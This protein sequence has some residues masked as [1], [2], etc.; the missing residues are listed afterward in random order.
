MCD[1]S[2]V[3]VR[4]LLDLKSFYDG[5]GLWI[6]FSGLSVPERYPIMRTESMVV[7][8]CVL[9]ENKETLKVS[10]KSNGLYGS[11]WG[12]RSLQNLCK[13]LCKN[14]KLTVSSCGLFLIEFGLL[15]EVFVI[16]ELSSFDEK[17]EFV[18]SFIATLWK[19]WT[20]SLTLTLVK[21]FQR[22]YVFLVCFTNFFFFFVPLLFEERRLSLT[23]NNYFPPS[24]YKIYKNLFPDRLQGIR[25]VGRVERHVRR[26]RHLVGR[27]SLPVS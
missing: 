18:L 19:I 10:S 4:S 7:W 16:Q 2:S 23:R 5:I 17:R 15:I 14:E 13:R 24:L 25:S 26:R 22:L 9:G 3:S 8:V 20:E 21:R 1:T 11:I 12:L 6:E 27:S